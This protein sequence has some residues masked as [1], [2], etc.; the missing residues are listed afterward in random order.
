[1]TDYRIGMS[2]ME[3]QYSKTALRKV[4]NPNVPVRTICL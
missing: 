3:S 4:H 1:M 2:A